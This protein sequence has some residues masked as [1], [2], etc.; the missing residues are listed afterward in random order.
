MIN[1]TGLQNTQYIGL[2]NMFQSP[3]TSLN[4]FY[5]DDESPQ[6]NT[7]LINL[8]DLMNLECS[9]GKKTAYVGKDGYIWQAAFAELAK[10]MS[11]Q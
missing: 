2:Q 8:D 7:G 10:G 4:G 11:E 6:T 5:N 9:L 1:L 3:K